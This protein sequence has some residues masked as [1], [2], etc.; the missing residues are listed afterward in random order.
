MTK[1]Q[2]QKD[3]TLRHCLTVIDYLLNNYHELINEDCDSDKADDYWLGAEDYLKDWAECQV[4]MAKIE[5]LEEIKN[6]IERDSNDTVWLD[7][8]TTMWD[9]VEIEIQKLKKQLK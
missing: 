1:E 2:H 6:I 9:A 5:A 8:S 7:D 3:E 4:I